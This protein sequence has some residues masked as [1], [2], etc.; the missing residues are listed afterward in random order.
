MSTLWQ[1]VRYGLRMLAKNPAFTLLAVLTLAL[2]IGANTALFSVVNGVL[3]NPLPFP[4]P[5]QL[6]RIHESKPNFAKGSISYPNFRDWQRDNHSYSMMAISRGT[7]FSLIGVGQAQRVTGQFVSS[8]FFRLLGVHPL[9][10]RSFAGREDEIGGPPLVMI[11]AGFWKEK[12]GG[13][14][15]IC[16]KALMLDGTSYT[17]I[18]VLPESFHFA[19]G[20]FMPSDVYV[21]I[22]QWTNPLLSSRSAGLGIHGLARLKPGV[23]AEQAQADMDALTR[24]LAAEYPE[25]NRGIGANVTP[26][27]QEMLGRIEPF[28]LVLMAAV[29]FVLLIAC[30]NVANLMLARS[31][32]RTREFAVRVAMGASQGRVLRQL[33]VESILLALAGGTVGLLLAQWGTQAGLKL[34]PAG[35]PRADEIAMDGRVLLFTAGISLAAGVLFGLVPA[36]RISKAGVQKTL[37]EAARGG[38]GV[39][40]RAHGI[41]VVSEMALAL[42]LLCGAGLMLRTLQWLWSVDPGFQPRGVLT[43]GAAFS[44]SLAT[45]SPSTIRAT[46]REFDS[47]LA[48]VPGVEALSLSWGAL[49]FRTDDET[50]FW[51]EGQPK[52]SS[53]SEMNW[54]LSYVVEANYLKTMG[55]PLLRGR[56]F[57]AQD[58]ERAPRVTVVDE[59]FARKYFGNQD[60]IGKHINL[61]E[62]AAM[63][64]P[65]TIVG[66][67]GHVKQWG[68][69][70]DDSQALRAE[71]YS[72]YMQLRDKAIAL[73]VPGTDVLVRGSLPPQ[74]LF[75]ALQRASRQMSNEQVIYGPQTMEELI[76]ASVAARRFT[77]ELLAIFAGLALVLA[78]IGIYGVMSY[79]VGRQTREIGIRMALGAQT[80]DV[81]RAVLG[82]GTRMALLGV[83]LGLLASLGLTQL[84]TRYSLLFG[85]SATDPSTF[86]A[87]T[88]LLT[89]V[90][91]LACWVPTR[92]ATRVDPLVALRYE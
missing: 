66:V 63:P 73:A 39:R 2:G 17:I 67:V 47:R 29:G 55:I 57:T 84:L 69:D 11:S 88:V 81:M 68:L 10:G 80:G 92:R 49:P 13:A 7:A 36:V 70:T 30:G 50:L 35:L 56:F 82:Q 1:D 60:P 74:T 15:D 41:F 51:L 79:L 26:L 91:V 28:L 42:V 72:P 18:G 34:I 85:V 31:A 21:A 25:S 9:L 4:Y 54:T 61:D 64:G 23:T 86:A 38:S 37:Q 44:P 59:V 12:L 65:V 14:R 78:C 40:Q 89:L 87:V 48:A 24:R 45:A 33:L 75:D 71:M 62:Q 90:A 19:V 43:F 27:R 77:M 83:G 20:G 3:L 76:S 58:D 52:P 46:L 16:G 8:D 5:E 6:V 53:M 32:D 22:G